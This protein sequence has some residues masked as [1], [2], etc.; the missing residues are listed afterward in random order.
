MFGRLGR[1][2]DIGVGLERRF[3]LLG[4][5]LDP[6]YPPDILYYLLI[7]LVAPRR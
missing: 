2:V 3:M 5:A 1:I 4:V 6:R 7:S